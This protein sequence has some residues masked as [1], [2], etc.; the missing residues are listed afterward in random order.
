MW[1]MAKE[2]GGEL[3]ASGQM[4][5][6]DMPWLD[7]EIRQSPLEERVWLSLPQGP[8]FLH[9]YET[10]AKENDDDDGGDGWEARRKGAAV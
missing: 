8:D 9:H 3:V 1:P 10:V 2:M 6:F 5:T 4:K 7:G